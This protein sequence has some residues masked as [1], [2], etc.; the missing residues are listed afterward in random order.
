MNKRSSGALAAALALSAAN[1]FARPDT[2]KVK[3]ELTAEFRKF[4]AAVMKKDTR[5]WLSLFAPDYT[6]KGG[7]RKDHF[8]QGVRG[9]DEDVDSR[10]EVRR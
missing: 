2:A 1:V 5:T 4:D 3:S 8:P 6:A 7:Q 10:D 9:G